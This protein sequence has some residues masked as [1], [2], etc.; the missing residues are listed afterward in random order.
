ML[1][2]HVDAQVGLPAGVLN[3]I[4]GLGAETGAPLSSSPRV[5][6]VAF[7]GSVATGR[8]VNLAAAQNLRPATMELGGKSCLVV[9][10]DAVLEHAIEW[11]MVSSV[12]MHS[13]HDRNQAPAARLARHS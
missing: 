4:T 13:E 1:D 2:W 12:S 9:F 11:V 5:A 8:N 6:K 3:V 7:T 10:D